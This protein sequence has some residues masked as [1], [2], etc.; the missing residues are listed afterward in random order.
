MPRYAA[1]TGSVF[2]FF[3]RCAPRLHLPPPPT[4][5]I[6]HTLHIPPHHH[7]YHHATHY[8]QF[9]PATTAPAFVPTVLVAFR[10]TDVPSCPATTAILPRTTPARGLHTRCYYIP[11]LFCCACTC[12]MPTCVATTTRGF[13]L[14]A[15]CWS[16][17]PLP[18]CMPPALY[19][20]LPFHACW[21]NTRFWFLH[22]LP[23]VLPLPPHSVHRAISA[24]TVPIFSRTVRLLPTA[25]C[26]DSAC[27]SCR[28]LPHCTHFTTTACVLC[29]RLLPHAHTVHFAACTPPPA[30]LRTPG[31]PVQISPH[32]TTTPTHT[33]RSSHMVLTLW[34]WIYHHYRSP[35]YHY[36]TFPTPPC[37]FMI[38]HLHSLPMP[39]TL[40]FSPHCLLLPTTYYYHSSQGQLITYTYITPTDFL[41]RWFPAFYFLHTIPHSASTFT[42]YTISAT[43]MGHGTHLHIFYYF[44]FSLFLPTL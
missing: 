5:V 11:R 42:T 16:T 6:H 10:F 26:L 32:T 4:A 20:H 15:P 29:H 28:V 18:T 12:H 30:V 3:F 43:W 38:H 34:D 25:T 1:A 37:V 31:S 13:C 41:P 22:L 39:Q 14:H 35:H 7:A 9:T 17:V 44:C 19:H 21:M 24:F 8:H 40:H 27:R 33:H 36:H 2:A 23:A